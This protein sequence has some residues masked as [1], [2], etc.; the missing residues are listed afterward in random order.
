MIIFKYFIIFLNL[1]SFMIIL[2]FE[3]SDLSILMSINEV[4]F[5][6]YMLQRLHVKYHSFILT[7]SCQKN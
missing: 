4:L 5:I 2:E 1:N 7:K 6:P 3:Y